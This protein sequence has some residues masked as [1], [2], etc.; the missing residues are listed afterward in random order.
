ML[1]ALITILLLGGSNTGMLDFIADTQDEVEVVMEKGDQRKEALSTLKAIKSRTEAHNEAV[2]GASKGL[3][4]ALAD[5]DATQ[6]DIDTNWYRYFAQ[7]EAY[8]RHM[9]DLRFQLKDQMTREEWQQVFG[10]N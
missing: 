3:N 4:K 2:T 9:L 7:R 5:N 10:N 1:I 8:N 6:V